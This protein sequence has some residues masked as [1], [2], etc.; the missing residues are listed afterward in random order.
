ME[1][2]Q[3]NCALRNL[4]IFKGTFACDAVPPNIP[5]RDCAIVLNTDRKTERGTHWVAIFY[6]SDGLAEY[7][8]SFGFLPM[9]ACIVDALDRAP[10]GW[11]YVPISLQDVRADTCGN[12][13]IAY[14]RARAKNVSLAEF[15]ALFT[16]DVAENEKRVKRMTRWRASHC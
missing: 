4:D 3:I 6:R 13:C 15:Y 7:F 10:N 11:V 2:D 5:H 8:D 16:R 1:T 12:Y 14:V 9:K